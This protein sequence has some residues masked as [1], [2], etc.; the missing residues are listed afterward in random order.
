MY[1]EGVEPQGED[2]GF[3]LAFCVEV[4]DICLLLFCDRVK[5]RVRVEEVGNESKIELGV[6]S[7]KG[8]WC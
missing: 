2:T 3:A 7:Y 8:G 5:T 1:V 6:S 4:V